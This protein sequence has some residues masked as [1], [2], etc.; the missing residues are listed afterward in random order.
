MWKRSW[1]SLPS[2]YLHMLQAAP[3]AQISSSIVNMQADGST[4]IMQQPLH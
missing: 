1:L 4:F 2:I 3:A